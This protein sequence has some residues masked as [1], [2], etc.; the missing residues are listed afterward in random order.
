VYRKQKK[1]NDL[2]NIYV[3]VISMRIVDVTYETPASRESH[4]VVVGQ[5]VGHSEVVEVHSTM[6][7]PL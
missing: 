2:T 4:K 3:L 6:S 7:S 1:I 5:I